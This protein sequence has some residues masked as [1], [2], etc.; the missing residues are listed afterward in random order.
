MHHIELVARDLLD[1]F[2]EQIRSVEISEFIT[3]STSAALQCI[4][5][6]VASCGKFILQQ[7]RFVLAITL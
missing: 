4:N 6:E 2:E 3:A 1:K 7:G 5:G